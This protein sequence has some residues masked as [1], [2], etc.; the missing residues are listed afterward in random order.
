MIRRP[1]RSTLFPY[2]TL[3]RSICFVLFNKPFRN[4]NRGN[5]VNSIN[6]KNCLVGVEF[7]VN[8]KSYLVKR[9]IKPNL[10]EIYEDGILLNQESSTRDY[11]KI[12]EDQILKYN[13]RTFTQVVILGSASF[14]PFM[15][16]PKASRREVIED[17][18]DIS[19][20]SAMNSITK[21]ELASIKDE[22]QDVESELK[23]LKVK[24]ESQEK[25]IKFIL[26]SKASQINEQ[27]E[28]L[29]SLENRNSEIEKLAS[30][31]NTKINELKSTISDKDEVLTNQRICEKKINTLETKMKY[32]DD[33]ISFFLEEDI[34]STCKQDISQE[35]K[36]KIID[37]LGQKKVKQDSNLEV[38]NKASLIL[39]ERMD[40]ILDVESQIK[41][42][43]DSV[44]QLQHEFSFNK[45]EIQKMNDEISKSNV[46]SDIDGENKKLTQIKT[47]GISFVERKKELLKQKQLREEALI[48]LKDNGIK[49]KIVK[50]YLP[51][52]NKSI[53]Q[54]LDQ[55]DFF[56]NFNIDEEFNEVIKSRY[57]DNFSYENFSQGEKQRIDI[58]IMLTFRE[59]AKMKNSLNCNLL[60]LD[61]IFSS[62]LDP[63]AVSFL[64]D[65][66]NSMESSN[67]FV[68]TH[69]PDD[70]EESF[71]R[72]I[73]FKKVNNFSVSEEVL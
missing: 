18:L 16:L 29:I 33:E 9:G 20:F 2:T 45:N 17:V 53:N 72:H 52:I 26:E 56:C 13:F 24:V 54:Y 47:E 55:M 69:H 37:D 31:L 23:I 39:N 41:K 63:T 21:N 22:Y 5:L 36:S 25:H 3:F 46:S 28:K 42:I 66:L 61:E 8:G 49:T 27:K 10:F 14:V 35:H 73:K 7:D 12:L 59:I 60:V 50:E 64:V 44:R 11:Q 48:L 58:A 43:T 65:L 1:P 6:G 32:V 38:L 40:V 67:T 70:I 51:V 30:E 68:I 62:T 4:I 15:E 57:R 34:C 71:G 19:I